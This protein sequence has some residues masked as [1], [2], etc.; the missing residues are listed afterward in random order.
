MSFNGVFPIIND[1]VLIWLGT[2]QTVRGIYIVVQ[3]GDG[4][5]VFPELIRSTDFDGS[6]TSEV[7]PGS[8]VAVT[9][10][11]QADSLWILSN[12]GT[13][14]NGYF[15]IGTD[16][17]VFTWFG[18]GAYTAGS[19]IDI[20]A[21]VVSLIT[22]VTVPLG[23]TGK[24]NNTVNAVLVGNGTNALTEVVPSGGSTI[25]PIY[26]SFDGTSNGYASIDTKKLSDFS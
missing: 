21:Q 20:T 18:P 1:W 10:G 24:T 7:S 3:T 11:P 26:L 19:G 23:G 4:S 15:D 14:P 2:D 22:P 5:S 25:T 13:L 16:P 17:L 8:V 6:P 9:S 12:S